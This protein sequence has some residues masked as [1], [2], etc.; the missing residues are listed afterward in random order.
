MIGIT[1]AN[2]KLG[3]LIIKDLVSR[4]LK[5]SIIAFVRSKEKGKELESLG[6][7]IRIADYNDETTFDKGLQGIDTLLLISAHDIGQRV[8]QHKHVIDG[9]KASEIKT[10]IYTSFIHSE[11]PDWTLLLEHFETEE[12]I[13]DSGIPYVIC[14]DSLYLDNMVNDIPRIIKEGAYYTSA[15]NGFAY[16][17]VFDLARTY[18]EI[19]AHPEKITLNSV[20]NFTGPELVTPEQYFNIIQAQTNKKLSF[21][22]VSEPDMEKYLH[23]LGISETSMDG[24]LGFERMQSQNLVSV[25]SDD[26]EKITGVTPKD[27]SSFIKEN[28][29]KL[30]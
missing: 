8:A 20:Y 18:A 4:G 14:R 6:V 9:A 1:G 7:K 28:P 19:L 2:G 24:W 3:T 12:M 21:K 15:S 11:R 29:L 26:I 13:V 22:K 27:M 16:V 10:I 23:S 5:D 17:S 30:H 25:V